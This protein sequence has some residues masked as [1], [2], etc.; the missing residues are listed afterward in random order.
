MHRADLPYCFTRILSDGMPA[1]ALA[2]RERGGRSHVFVWTVTFDAPL[3]R[4]FLFAW[5][6][7]NVPRWAI[8]GAVAATR[9]SAALSRCIDDAVGQAALSGAPLMIQIY[10][11]AAYLGCSEIDLLEFRER[12]ECAALFEEEPDP[13]L[14]ES[15][16]T[17]VDLGGL[18]RRM[19]DDAVA[20]VREN[21]E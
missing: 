9:G 18:V 1:I 7:R 6:E 2:R 21:R 15:I 17:F 10:R 5:L 11:A 8:W 3:Y 16:I 12:A 14:E 20:S 13:L 4:E 19:I